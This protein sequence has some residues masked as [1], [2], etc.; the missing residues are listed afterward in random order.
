MKLIPK[1]ASEI[2]LKPGSM[3]IDE[4]MMLI[5]ILLN[6]RDLREHVFGPELTLD[7]AKTV[8]AKLRACG[9]G[10]KV[11]P[12]SIPDQPDALPVGHNKITLFEK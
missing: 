11:E 1:K 3:S 10:A 7:D 5:C 4:A 2:I 9:W 6:H 12:F 8:V